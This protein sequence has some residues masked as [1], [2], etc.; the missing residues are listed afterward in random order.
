M[1]GVGD[2][3][4]L[5]DGGLTVQHQPVDLPEHV[6]YLVEVVFGRQPGSWEQPVVV[7]AALAVDEHELHSRRGGELAEEVGDEHG[8]AEPGQPTD[9]RP[10][11]LGQPNEDRRAVL[12]PAQ[13]P[14][15]QRGGSC[16]G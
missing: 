2:P 10:G 7:G 13:P 3:E 12:G 8:L 16:A 4:D 6:A 9:H 11:D 1:P 5:G 15:L 14:R